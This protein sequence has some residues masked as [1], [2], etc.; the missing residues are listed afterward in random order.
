[1]SDGVK[2][3]KKMRK[4]LL[5]AAATFLVFSTAAFAQVEQPS[6]V[7]IQGTALITKD[8]TS[9]S[10]STLNRATKSGGFLLGY[11]Y[12]FNNWAGVEG[13]YGYTR[14]TQNYFGSFGQ[15][16]VE[17]NTHELTGS[18]V[19]HIPVKVANGRPYAFAHGGALVFD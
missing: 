19:F 16:A 5:A 11:S 4:T 17:A 6:Q 10:T 12:Q 3:E 7:S 9:D 13:N 1:M 2:K 8:T 15:S 14:N 18:V